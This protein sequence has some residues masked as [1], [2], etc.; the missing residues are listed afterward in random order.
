MSNIMQ[1]IRWARDKSELE[2][3]LL[4]YCEIEYRPADRAQAMT[5]LMNSARACYLGNS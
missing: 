5:A 4:K 3:S 1:K 2:R